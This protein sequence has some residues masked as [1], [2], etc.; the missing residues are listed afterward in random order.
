MNKLSL[1]KKTEDQNQ[2]WAA[3]ISA[4]FGKLGIKTAVHEKSLMVSEIFY[5]AKHVPLLKSQNALAQEAA[6]Q[7]NRY[8]TNPDMQFDLPMIPKGSFY[9]NKVWQQIAQIPLG[10]VTT[11]GDLAKKLNSAPRAI[12]GACGANPYPLIVPCHRV[13]SATGIGGFA[14]QDEEGYHRNIKTWLLQHEGV[15]IN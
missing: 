14:Q 8:F 11:Y 15:C 5:V 10:K 4:P 2:E 9:Q 12:G 7:I 13:V 3:V 6:N 1:L